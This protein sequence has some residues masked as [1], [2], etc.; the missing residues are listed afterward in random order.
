MPSVF[1]ESYKVIA[2]SLHSFLVIIH[3]KIQRSEY[4]S[5]DVTKRIEI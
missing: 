1:S 2:V 4:H 3:N 5:S